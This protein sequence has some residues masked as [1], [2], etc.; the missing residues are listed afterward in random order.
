MYIPDFGPQTA[1]IKVILSKLADRTNSDVCDAIFTAPFAPN[2]WDI[3]S[4]GKASVSKVSKAAGR[5][6]NTISATVAA[7]IAMTGENLDTAWA[8]VKA[9]E[10]GWSVSAIAARDLIGDIFTQEQYDQLTKSMMDFLAIVD[11][12]E[13]GSNERYL[14]ID[15]LRSLSGTEAVEAAKQSLGGGV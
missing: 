6:S 11:G 3:I 14:A 5:E 9:A 12:T 4:A 2:W 1:E 7:S 15:L 13:P 10:P 8:R